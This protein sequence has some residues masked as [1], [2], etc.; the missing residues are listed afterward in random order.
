MDA[1]PDRESR[2]RQPLVIACAW[3]AGLHAALVPD[4]WAESDAAGVAFALSAL[5]LLAVALAVERVGGQRAAGAA[6]LLLAALLAIYVASRLTPV[7]PLEHA[8]PV[9]AV[10]AVTKL[11]EAIGL[12]LALGLLQTPRRAVKELSAA[13]KGVDP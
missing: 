6:A 7:W 5:M 12:V 2:L 10:G 8:E 3:S 9:D 1:H 11:F 4:H 13:T